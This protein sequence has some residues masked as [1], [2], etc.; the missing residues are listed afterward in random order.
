MAK[1]N[2]KKTASP[3]TPKKP[4]DI[5]P[6]DEIVELRERLDRAIIERNL[7]ARAVHNLT[8]V[9]P[10][11]P[12]PEAEHLDVRRMSPAAGASPQ[13]ARAAVNYCLKQNSSSGS[14][15]QDQTRLQNIPVN[16]DDVAICLNV[17]YLKNANQFHPGEVA[18]SWT[19]LRLIGETE[20]KHHL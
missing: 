1:P 14:T 7:L 6:P 3:H 12:A 20:S 5:V 2:S 16:A 8:A 19:V 17:T 13:N 4:K 18:P 9:M 10:A 15:W 11:R